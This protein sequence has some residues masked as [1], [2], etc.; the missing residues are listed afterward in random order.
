M[1]RFV[2][3][4]VESADVVL[5]PSIIVSLEDLDGGFGG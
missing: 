3:R 4:I 5:S 1:A 2:E